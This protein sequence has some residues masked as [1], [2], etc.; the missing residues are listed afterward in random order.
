MNDNE[1]A[2]YIRLKACSYR[3]TPEQ[4]RVL[5]EQILDGDAVG[6]MK[7]LKTILMQGRESD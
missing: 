2:A 5:R 6:A 3:L 7:E 1:A 4:Y